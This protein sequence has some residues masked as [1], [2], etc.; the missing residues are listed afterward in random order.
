MQ[1]RRGGVKLSPGSCTDP[2]A[3][4]TGGASCSTFQ[5]PPLMLLLMSPISGWALVRG[6]RTTWHRFHE[7][8]AALPPGAWTR[9]LGTLALGLGLATGLA[10]GLVLAGKRMAAAGMAAWDETALRRLVDSGWL[11]FDGGVWWQSPGN[12]V[13]LVPLLLTLAV[14]AARRRRPLLALSFPLAYAGS[15]FLTHVGWAAWD[16][17]RPTF[18]ADGVASMGAHAYPSGHVINVLGAFG[19]VAYLWIERSGRG[20]ERAVAVLLLLALA[21]IVGVARLRLGAHW[22]SDVLAGLVLGTVWAAVL[23][24]ALRRGEATP[25]LPSD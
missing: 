8:T 4:C 20:V 2:G 7:G 14:V 18:V 11:S 5:V 3:A 12:S 22:P 23:A 1:A 6:A 9:W 25:D 21:A 19:L 10:L 24:A 16:R 17:A 13:V 15:K